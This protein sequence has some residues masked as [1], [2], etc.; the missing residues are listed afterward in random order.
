MPTIPKPDLK[1]ATKPLYAG[2]GVTDLDVRRASLEDTYLSVV[3]Q[4]AGVG[5]GGGAPSWLTPDQQ[6]TEGRHE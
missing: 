4:H 1:V 3:A 6:R 2:A 5:S